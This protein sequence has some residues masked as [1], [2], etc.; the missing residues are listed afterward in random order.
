MVVYSISGLAHMVAFLLIWG[1]AGAA[2][3]PPPMTLE[4]SLEATPPTI[5]TSLD[6]PRDSAPDGEG[7]S[8][9]AVAANGSLQLTS[10]IIH[11][12]LPDFGPG[13][14]AASG[15]N[16]PSIAIYAPTENGTLGTRV[17]SERA[18]FVSDR[19][20]PLDAAVATPA[21]RGISGHAVDPNASAPFSFDRVASA[22][23]TQ[24]Q[25]LLA[26]L[27]DYPRAC[28][29]GLCR[30]GRPCESS[31]IW[32]IWV[33]AQGGTPTKIQ[34]F[35]PMECELQNASIRKYFSEQN[36]PKTAA[37]TAYMFTV[38]MMML[39]YDEKR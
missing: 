36:F 33:A 10:E 25:M 23:A 39:Y 18:A 28:R 6:A 32:K 2:A 22:M 26:G 30:N 37:P 20:A 3:V 12:G 9:A 19:D 16:V 24:N 38:P 17:L 27:P 8:I 15:V 14:G 13:S 21:R 31:S 35:D 1:N 34:C 7:R 11:G 5:E 29:R 4:M